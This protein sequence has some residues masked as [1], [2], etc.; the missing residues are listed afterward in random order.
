MQPCENVTNKRTKI[1]INEQEILQINCKRKEDLDYTTVTVEEI[2]SGNDTATP[3][4]LDLPGDKIF[5]IWAN[6]SGTKKH[7]M[8][9]NNDSNIITQDSKD[10]K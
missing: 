6:A 4:I 2:D 3:E 8:N 7:P 5:K 9:K 1:L 10:N